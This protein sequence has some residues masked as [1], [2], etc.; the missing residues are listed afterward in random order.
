MFKFRNSE[1]LDKVETALER[2]DN[3]LEALRTLP[4]KLEIEWEDTLDKLGRLH[5]RLNQRARREV[6]ATPERDEPTPEK[7]QPSP[8]VVGDHQVLS[9][10]RERVFGGRR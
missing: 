7:D 2:L 10:M 1:R 3:K 4:K 9:T 8:V 6:L 5:A